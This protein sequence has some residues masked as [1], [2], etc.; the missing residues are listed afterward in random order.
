MIGADWL[1]LQHLMVQHTVDQ[2]EDPT[3]RLMKD[4]TFW[5]TTTHL[6][7]QKSY[8]SVRSRAHVQ[9]HVNMES[10]SVRVLV[11]KFMFESSMLR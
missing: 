9:T 5:Q 1:G 4:P 10:R 2:D 11:R 3:K 6:Y 8:E 7:G